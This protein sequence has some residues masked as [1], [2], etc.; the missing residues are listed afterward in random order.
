MTTY[1]IFRIAEV[2]TTHGPLIVYER[3]SWHRRERLPRYVVARDV[4][5]GAIFLEE[6]R[7]K[8]S[9]LKWAKAQS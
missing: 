9:A 6:F 1:S 4:Q 7:R 2:S 3:G 8:A 5:N